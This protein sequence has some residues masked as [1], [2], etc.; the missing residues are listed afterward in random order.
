MPTVARWL[1]RGEEQLEAKIETEGGKQ[2]MALGFQEL[3]SG[4]IGVPL[5]Q[6]ASSNVSALVGRESSLAKMLDDVLPHVA[7][8]LDEA[9]LQQFPM[10][11]PPDGEPPQPK[12]RGR[13][14]GSTNW[15]QQRFWR[16]YLETARRLSRPYRRTHLAAGMGLAYM[17]FLKYF[18]LWGPPPGSFGPGE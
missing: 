1:S 8:L 10:F 7:K 5:R 6:S 11:G 15:T 16:K 13:K 17:T 3:N 2:G 4:G 14:P 12:H 9:L 18:A